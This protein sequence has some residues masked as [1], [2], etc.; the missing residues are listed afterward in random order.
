M[1]EGLRVWDEGGWDW[2][3]NQLSEFEFAVVFLSKECLRMIASCTIFTLPHNQL[4]AYVKA[5][6]CGVKAVGLLSEV[7]VLVDDVPG[8]LRSVLF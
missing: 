3:V 1:L 5:A 7:W 8:D 6:A 4:V 2:Q